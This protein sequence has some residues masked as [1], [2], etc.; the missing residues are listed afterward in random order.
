MRRPLNRLLAFAAWAAA[1]LIVIAAAVPAVPPASARAAPPSPAAPSDVYSIIPAPGVPPGRVAAAAEALG[2]RVRA[3]SD[4]LV[5]VE[6]AP[7]NPYR[8]ASSATSARSASAVA[9]AAV[10]LEASGLAAASRPTQLVHTAVSAAPLHVSASSAL[11]AVSAAPN[12]PYWSQQWDMAKI[13]AALG[14]AAAGSLAPVTVAVIDTGVD[15]S[16]PDLAGRVVGPNTNTIGAVSGCS[17]PASGVQD[18]NGHGTHVAGIIAA[19]PNNG[20]GIAGTAPNARLMIVKALDCTGTGTT[21]TV[22]EG[23]DWAAAH[24]AR[25]ISMSL[26]DNCGVGEDPT[27][28]SAIASAAAQGIALVAAAGNEGC[29]EKTYPAADSHVVAVGASTQSDT[30]ASFSNYGSWVD[31]YAP[32]VSIWSTYPGGSYRQM[33][34]TSMAAPHVSG[35]IAV[36]MGMGRSAA[37]AENMVISSADTVA[38]GRRLNLYRAALAAGGTPQ[39]TATPTPSA[40]PSRTPTPWPTSTWTPPPT[41][42]VTAT[43]T[44]TPSGPTI[45]PGFNPLVW[46]GPALTGAQAVRQELDQDGLRGAWT[47]VYLPVPGTNPQQWRWLFPQGDSNTLDG[48]RPGQVVVIAATVTRQ[49]TGQ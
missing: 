21:D 35:A 4:Q 43:P 3:A 36:L 38:A 19:V 26:A 15:L 2:L 10:M 1:A 5:T 45:Y 48:L 44:P 13:Q 39:A 27:L 32:G 24:G 30:R 20:I 7:P 17:T 41:P 29:S 6:S 33:S 12:D 9:R 37:Q 49:W 34:G 14:W 16:H 46:Q 23:I 42:S 8:S 22:A 25:V 40:T 18:D 31:L 28:A 11:S 47:A